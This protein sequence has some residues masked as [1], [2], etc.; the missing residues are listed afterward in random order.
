MVALTVSGRRPK[1]TNAKIYEGRIDSGRS[2]A[3]GS[4]FRVHLERS[5]IDAG[6]DRQP[7]ILVGC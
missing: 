5:R 6:N 3:S 4:A 2:C 7:P 1:M